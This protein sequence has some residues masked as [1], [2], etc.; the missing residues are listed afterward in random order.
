MKATLTL[1]PHP[2]WKLVLG[3]PQAFL[4]QEYNWSLE[5]ECTEGKLFHKNTYPKHPELAVPRCH[6]CLAL[7]PPTAFQ[8]M[9][10]WAT[11]HGFTLDPWHGYQETLHIIHRRFNQLEGATPDRR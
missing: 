7:L 8:R 10:F 2:R 5:H 11:Y 9:C 6:A 3:Y 1:V 4:G